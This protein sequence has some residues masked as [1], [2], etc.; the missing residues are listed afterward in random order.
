MIM[1]TITDGG[2]Q[3]CVEGKVMAS[4]VELKTEYCEKNQEN[5][6]PDDQYWLGLAYREGK[7][8]PKDEAKAK[9]WF[10]RAADP[11]H[12]EAR[13]AFKN[14]KII[15][16][17][18]PSAPLFW[19][20]FDD[21]TIVKLVQAMDGPYGNP[22]TARQWL[23]AR[24]PNPTLDFVRDCKS[25]LLRTWLLNYNDLE[26]IVARLMDAGVGPLGKKPTSRDELLRYI[27]KTKATKTLQ[28][29][30]LEAMLRFPDKLP[31]DWIPSGS[32]I[33]LKPQEQP[34][35]E[36]EPHPFQKEASDRLDNSLREFES[37]KRFEGIVVMP[38]GSGKT[39]TTVQWLLSKVLVR[40]RFKVLW[41]A[42]R[43]ELLNQAA[44]DFV[45]LSG[46][47]S[48]SDK[49]E[50]RLRIVSGM[51]CKTSQI[52]KDED[53]VI[54]SVSSLS[55]NPH[56]TK[57]LIIAIL[58]IKREKNRDFFYEMCLKEACHETTI[59]PTRRIVR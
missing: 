34:R 22:M 59:C 4:I 51:H 37:S 26:G 58:E 55:R 23:R 45:R 48:Q 44:R 40:E 30:V 3:F 53:V 31:E 42:H 33:I 41:L 56:V 20:K 57:E 19:D 2:S 46:L 54:A 5:C 9:K 13:E 1:A 10:K 16:Q 12:P 17:T 50:F 36:R 39:Y 25:V 43:H 6:S 38:T 21:N 32:I 35:D 28:T 14:I 15:G 8:V 49:Q 18:D 29:I 27:E 52:T 7:D 47:L 11:G 24:V